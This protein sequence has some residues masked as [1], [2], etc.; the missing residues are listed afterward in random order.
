MNAAAKVFLVDD[1][2]PFLL[3]QSRM[4]EAAGMPVIAF[5]SAA[6]LL[7]RVSPKE[8]GCI[9][10]DLFMPG[11][12]G[13]ELQAALTAAGVE[14]PI[15]FLTGRPDIPSTVH[16]MRD[17]AVDFLEKTAPCE[18][19]ID[20]I[21]RALATDVLARESRQYV[22]ELRE[23][24]ALLTAREREVLQFVL[25][26]CMNKQIAAQLGIHE[27]TV[28]LH[29]TAIT[30]KLGVRSAIQISEMAH[31]AG[32]VVS[33]PQVVNVTPPGCPRPSR[34]FARAPEIRGS[35]G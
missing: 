22:A 10:T 14:L 6:R 9:V 35:T 23:R 5:D 34:A 11:M 15:V 24:F 27:R 3:A 29:R 31:E 17:G 33:R 7:A 4:L 13:L 18:L 32:I 21:R 16:A 2:V 20:S 12:S 28:K 1:D 25:T 8:H 30:M 19:L 26:G